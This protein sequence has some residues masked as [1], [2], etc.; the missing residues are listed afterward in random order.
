MNYDTIK[1]N[2]QR[3]LW[4]L[5]QVKAAVRK[6]VITVAQYEETTGARYQ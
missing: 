6:G 2:F 5:A 3:G 1:R 4:S